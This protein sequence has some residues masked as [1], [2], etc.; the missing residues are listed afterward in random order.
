[1]RRLLERLLRF[2]ITKVPFVDHVA[3]DCFVQDRRLFGGGQFR[4]DDRWQRLVFNAHTFDG[5]FGQIAAL[6][7]HHGHRL[8]DVTHLVDGNAPVLHR[9]THTHRER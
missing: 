2:A 5:V 1:M 6:S 7:D 3:A 8:S 9:L 4:I